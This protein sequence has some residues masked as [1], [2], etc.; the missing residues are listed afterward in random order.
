MLKLNGWP[1]ALTSYKALLKNK[2]RYGT[3]CPTS[4]SVLILKKDLSHVIFYQIAKFHSL[5]VFCSWDTGQFMSFEILVVQ[6]VT[7]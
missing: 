3:S 2:K 5:I 7:S 1:V 6:P 4:F